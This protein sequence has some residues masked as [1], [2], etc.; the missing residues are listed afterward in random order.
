MKA[1]AEEA[2][3]ALAAAGRTLPAQV[4]PDS[5]S[6]HILYYIYIYIYFH[7][8]IYVNTYINV[9]IYIYVIVYRCNRG[10]SPGGLDEGGRPGGRLP[11]AAYPGQA[12]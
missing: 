9:H 11:P 1:G 8:Y 5:P 2:A 3:F 4:P 10:V 7:V 6:A 12:L